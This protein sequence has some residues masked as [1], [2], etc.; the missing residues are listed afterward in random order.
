M[1][2]SQDILDTITEQ[3]GRYSKPRKV[4]AWNKALASWTPEVRSWVAQTL[5]NLK[6]TDLMY[7]RV[8]KVV[9]YRSHPADNRDVLVFGELRPGGGNF[10]DRTNQLIVTLDGRA[11]HKYWD[12]SGIA[13]TL[14]FEDAA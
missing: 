5:S 10:I 4:E 1:N 8:A 9:R 6:R 11:C 14:R 7:K 2:D 13:R 12:V 3:V